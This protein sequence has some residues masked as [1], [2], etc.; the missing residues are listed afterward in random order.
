MLVQKLKML[1][2]SNSAAQSL[3]EGGVDGDVPL[4]RLLPEGAS[5]NSVSP[6]SFCYLM[7]LLFW[8]CLFVH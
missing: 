4:T 6:V 3:V 7:T 2:K 8:C 5:S 1:Q